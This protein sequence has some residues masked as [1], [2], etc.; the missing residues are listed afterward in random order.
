MTSLLKTTGGWV[1]SGET[2]SSFS[3]R[4]FSF[5]DSGSSSANRLGSID[6]GAFAVRSLLKKQTPSSGTRQQEK[7]GDPKETPKYASISPEVSKSKAIGRDGHFI[8][9]SNGIIKDTKTGLEWIAGP[10]GDTNWHEAERWIKSLKV[11]GSGWRMPTMDELESLYLKGK[12]NRNM[13]PLLKTTGWWIWSGEIKD[14]SS[15]RLFS[16]F[17][18][19]SSSANRLGSIDIGAFAVRSRR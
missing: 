13:T 12:G 8:A 5:F 17:D 9:Y 14:S 2:K 19:G 10:D 3:A 16:F 11:S 1:W 4:L 7:Q 6:I 18:S 15:A